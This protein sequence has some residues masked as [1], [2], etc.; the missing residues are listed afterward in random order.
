[1]LGVRMIGAC[2]ISVCIIGMCMISVYMNITC[3][4]MLISMS[5]CVSQESDQI[6]SYAAE[7]LQSRIWIAVARGV[8]MIPVE[9]QVV[10]IQA[11]S[12]E[13][14]LQSLASLPPLQV[15]YSPRA[16]AVQPQPWLPSAGASCQGLSFMLDCGGACE[17]MD[18][19]EAMTR[20]AQVFHALCFVL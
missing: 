2:I 3:A 6:R 16:L 10:V 15:P 7:C 11:K 9:G 19:Q 1:M 13:I 12:E 20:L 8:G 18:S 14:A 4:G 17:H 5:T